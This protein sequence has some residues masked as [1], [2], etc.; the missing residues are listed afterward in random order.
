MKPEYKFRMKTYLYYLIVEPWTTKFHLP[1][2]RTLTWIF[3][4]IS[5]LLKKPILLFISIGLG[6]VL[7]AVNEYKSGKH[8][9]WYKQRKYKERDEALKKIREERK[10]RVEEQNIK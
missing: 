7:H 5:F 1:N 2:L 6:V 3:I 4:V 9:Y 8:I 10:R